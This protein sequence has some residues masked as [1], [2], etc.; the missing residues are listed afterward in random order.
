MPLPDGAKLLR[1]RGECFQSGSSLGRAAVKLPRCKQAQDALLLLQGPRKWV[2]R[3]S[4]AEEA[5]KVRPWGTLVGGHP[6][7]LHGG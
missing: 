7:H 6:G 5:L 3:S 1:A 4:L 2:C